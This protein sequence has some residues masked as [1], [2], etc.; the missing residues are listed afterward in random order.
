MSATLP[1]ARRRA[2]F[3]RQARVERERLLMEVTQ[4]IEIGERIRQLRNA[5]PYTNRSI[6]D[7]VGVGERAVAAWAGGETGMTWENAKK[8]AELFEVDVHWLWSGRAKPDAPDL[9]AQLNGSSADRL[10]RMEQTLEELV[11]EVRRLAGDQSD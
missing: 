7:Y 10:A 9:V 6:A 11:A 2:T 1:I 4:R 5:S 3:Q 8:L